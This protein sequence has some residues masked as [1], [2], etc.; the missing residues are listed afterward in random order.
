MPLQYGCGRRNEKRTAGKTLISK[1]VQ[2]VQESIIKGGKEFDNGY[3]LC[4]Q[5]LKKKH[6]V[7]IIDDVPAGLNTMIYTQIFWAIY[8][9]KEKD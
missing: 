9:V 1:A 6:N 5:T 7:Y 4:L 3:G 8:R 2:E